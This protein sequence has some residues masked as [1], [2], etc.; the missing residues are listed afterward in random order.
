M[1]CRDVQR[2]T[3]G[4][5]EQIAHCFKAEGRRTEFTVGRALMPETW[6]EMTFSRDWTRIISIFIT[7]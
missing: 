7:A 3:R 1:E 5:S 4:V 2:T 6:A